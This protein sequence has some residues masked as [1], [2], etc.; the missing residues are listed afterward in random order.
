MNDSSFQG[1]ARRFPLLFQN[2]AQP[3]MDRCVL[4]V[5]SYL[6]MLG[7]AFSSNLDWSSY[8]VSIAKTA[9]K[10]IEALI[11]F[12]KFLFS[13][14]ALYLYKST[15]RPCME[16]CYHVWAANPSCYLKLLDKLQKWICKTIEP[17]LVVSL[18]SL[19]HRRN[20]F[21]LSLFYRYYFG[22]CSSK[23]TQLVP[24]PCS[25]GWS[26]HYSDRLHDYSVTIRRFYKHVNVNGFFLCTARLWNS[27]TLKCFPL[28]YGLN[29][30]KSRIKR[31]LL[32][33]DSF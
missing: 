10:K 4:E 21:R 13:E 23:L 29:G 15:I 32:T 20:V 9:S 17:S 33:V 8:V 5:E 14:V 22:R 31:H 1:L 25:R 7:L 6:K 30:F 11:R 12:M 27:L 19:A 26:T 2:N 24:L 28:T 16:Y 3:A 18:K